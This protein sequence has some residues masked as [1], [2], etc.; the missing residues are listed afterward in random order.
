M[1]KYYVLHVFENGDR[2]EE[3]GMSKSDAV[4]EAKRLA[5]KFDDRKIFITTSGN[6]GQGC[7]Y[8]PDGNHDI[9]GQAWK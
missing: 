2:H 7:Y 4:K 1:K 9:T 5:E 3:E 8:N 6:S